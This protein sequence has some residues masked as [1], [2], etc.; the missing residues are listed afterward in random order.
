[1]VDRSVSAMES[2]LEQK[3]LQEI[4]HLILVGNININIMLRIK[5]VLPMMFLIF[6]IIGLYL[7]YKK[8]AIEYE[9]IGYLPNT[10]DGFFP[11]AYV[12]FHSNEELEQFTKLTTES[13]IIGDKFDDLEL[14][15]NQYSYCVFLGKEL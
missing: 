14:N 1:M 13:K 2:I 15:F 9:L 7:F 5:F 3:K 4:L 8:N 6:V 11:N 10:R 12:F